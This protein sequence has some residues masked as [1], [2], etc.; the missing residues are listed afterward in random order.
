MNRILIEDGK[1]PIRFRISRTFGH[2]QPGKIFHVASQIQDLLF[3][4]SFLNQAF[5]ER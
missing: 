5:K 1:T 4:R 3:F 2:V